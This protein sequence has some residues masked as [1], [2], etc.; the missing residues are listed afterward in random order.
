MIQNKRPWI[1]SITKLRIPASRSKQVN[2]T[3]SA[4]FL[5]WFV[6]F[7]N[8]KQSQQQQILINDD[9]E[10]RH[11]ADLFAEILNISEAFYSIFENWIAISLSVYSL[12]YVTVTLI[13]LLSGESQ[14]LVVF[15]ASDLR[16][17]TDSY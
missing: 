16:N 8:T 5:T 2:V 15:T 4:A 3:I 14:Y 17:V 11:L 10:M 13:F 6:I 12:L 7:S 1:R 9:G